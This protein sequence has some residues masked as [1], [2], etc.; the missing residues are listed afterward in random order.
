MPSEVPCTIISITSPRVASS[1]VTTCVSK[2]DQLL[3]VSPTNRPS[4]CLLQQLGCIRHPV[5]GDDNCLYY[6]VAHQSSLIGQDCHGD[7]SIANQLRTLALICMQKYPDVC[8]EDGMTPHQWE[9]K[10]LQILCH[11]EWGGDLEVR[12]LAIGLSREIIVITSSMNKST[13]A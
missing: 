9:E 6:L 7:H 3:S 13:F 11:G 12:L 8:L 10:K 1:S 2:E 5:N 4:I